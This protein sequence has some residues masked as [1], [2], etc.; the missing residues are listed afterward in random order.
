MKIKRREFLQKSAL[1]V[2]GVSAAAAGVTVAGLA[3]EW[4]AGLED[5]ER[6]RG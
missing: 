5:P 2:A 1:V 3:A 4:T 6:A